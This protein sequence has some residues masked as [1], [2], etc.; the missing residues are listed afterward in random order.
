MMTGARKRADTIVVEAGRIAHVG[1][2]PRPSPGALE[3]DGTGKYLIPGLWDMHTH[4]QMT[5]VESLGLYVANGVVGTRDMGSDADFILPLRERIRRGE[6][7][8][9]VIVAAGP[10]LDAAP[11]G[12]PYRRRVETPEQGREA[13]RKL[14][15]GGVDFIKVHDHTGREAFFAIADESARLGL[16]FAGHVPARVSVDETAAA[17]MKSIEHLA[18]S[19][20]YLECAGTPSGYSL[21]RCRSLFQRLAARGVW[22][23]PTLAFY[24]ALPSLLSGESPAH[25]EYASDGFLAFTRANTRASSLSPEAISALRELAR[26]NLNA[27]RDL[28]KT[29]S[30]FLAGCDGLVPGFCLHDE[31][32]WMVRAGFTPLQALRTATPKPRRV[33]R[34]RCNHRHDRCRQAGGPRAAGRRPPRRHQ[35]H[36]PH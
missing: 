5:G 18:N 4:H 31:L 35:Q 17:G 19:R 12:W 9:P 26:V 13:V 30:R 20:V 36:P 32:E 29:G 23:S 7:F 21:A 25:V 16:P 14:K 6:T 8:G 2:K 28:L 1:E 11:P 27:T 34:A 3:V 24:Q 15:G 33:P 22:Q 10:I